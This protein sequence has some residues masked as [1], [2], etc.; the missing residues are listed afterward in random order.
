MKFNDIFR[1]SFLEGF[2]GVVDTTY[3]ISALGI[4]AL[5]AIYIFFTYRVVTRKTFYNKNFNISLATI[6]VITAAIIL[7][8]QSNVVISL[9]MVGALSIV[10]FRTAIKDPL[11]LTFLFW[12]ISVG[13]ICGAGLAQIAVILSLL[14]TVGIFALDR[15]PVGRAPLMLIVNAEGIAQEETILAVVQKYTKSYAV[16]SRSLTGTGLDLVVE[17]RLRE[18]RVVVKEVSAIPGVTSTA[19]LSHDGEVTY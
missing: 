16:K 4:S 14:L 18:E 3:I 19:L 5:L 6:S 7:A 8:V 15:L 1:K 2:G 12:S 10:R 13:I 9:G 17:L 11:D